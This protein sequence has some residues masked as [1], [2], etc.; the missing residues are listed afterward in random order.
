MAHRRLREPDLGRGVGDVAVLHQRP[1]HHERVEVE[2]ANMHGANYF[3]AIIN[4]NNDGICA[5]S[6]VRT[7][8]PVKRV[9]P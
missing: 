4:F 1:E 2:A 6:G 9:C 5:M 3:I 7:V 8:S